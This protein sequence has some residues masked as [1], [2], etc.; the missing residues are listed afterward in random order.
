[1]SRPVPD[2]KTKTPS[3]RPVLGLAAVIVGFLVVKAFVQAD[4]PRTRAQ[5]A[6]KA[7]VERQYE[8]LGYRFD[9]M[10]KNDSAAQAAFSGLSASEVGVK[11]RELG[12]FGIRRL[13]SKD[14][15]RPQDALKASGLVGPTHCGR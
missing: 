2:P 11:A 7:R 8:E 15:L 6:S 10:L 1:M 3:G 4:N 12:R 13:D 9:S 14:L 5:H